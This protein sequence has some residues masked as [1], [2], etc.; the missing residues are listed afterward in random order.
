MRFSQKYCLFLLLILFLL[1]SCQKTINPGNSKGTVKLTFNNKVNGSPM[2]L[3]TGI[4]TNP[5]GETYTI[6]KFK[7][8]ISNVRLGL[9]GVPTIA[10]ETE[11]YHLID[12]SVPGSLSFSFEA[13]E[14]SF[15]T[16]SFLLGVDSTRNVSGA[17]TGALDPLNDM[18]WTWN[19]GYVMV[20]MEGTSPQ[21][22]QPGN[23]VQYHIGGFSGANNVLKYIGMV[24]PGGKTVNIK[25]GQTSEI[26]LEADFNKWWQS[27]NDIKIAGL[28]V[29]TTP[30]AQAKMVADNYSKMFTITDIVNN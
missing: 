23:V 6:T 25:K 19:S 3:N 14:N 2:A 29:C 27:P 28:P 10:A 26:T 11:S 8:Y 18:F 20:K 7:Y 9:S 24:F 16:L 4:Y 12:Q 1:S 15:I 5:F 21:S 13:D 17:Q 30:G 22:G